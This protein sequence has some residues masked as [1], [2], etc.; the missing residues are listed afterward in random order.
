MDSS[1][2][3]ANGFSS[4]AGSISSTSYSNFLYGETT[5]LD[6]GIE[7]IKELISSTSSS[8]EGFVFNQYNANEKLM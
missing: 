4:S 5:S 7:G 3:I 2:D 8:C 1:G 6:Y